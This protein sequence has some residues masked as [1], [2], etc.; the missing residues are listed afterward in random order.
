MKKFEFM[1]YDLNE[2]AFEIYSISDF[3]F[4][5]DD[6]G[7]FWCAENSKAKPLEKLETLKDVEEYLLLFA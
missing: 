4:Y 1:P 2:K 5:I 7:C 6:S 3:T